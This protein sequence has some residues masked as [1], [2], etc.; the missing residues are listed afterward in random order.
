VGGGTGWRA[1]NPAKGI[2]RVE[3]KSNS[4][5]AVVVSGAAI[6]VTWGR[7]WWGRIEVGDRWIVGGSEAG[8]VEEWADLVGWACPIC[9]YRL[10]V[11]T[12]PRTPTTLLDEVGCCDQ[13]DVG[14]CVAGQDRG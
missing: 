10:C 3:R 5:S 12:T 14:A 11:P 6:S 1:L 4:V 2:C 7:V 9:R 8:K 13:R